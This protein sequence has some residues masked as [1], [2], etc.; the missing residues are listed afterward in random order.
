MQSKAFAIIGLFACVTLLSADGDAFYW[1]NEPA[2]ASS[3]SDVLVPTTGTFKAIVFVVEFP[4]FDSNYVED[5]TIYPTFYDSLIAPNVDV[6]LT[7]SN[8]KWSITNFIYT[9]SWKQL[10]GSPLRTMI[11]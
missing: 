11:F 2:E 7:D 5:D 4:D 3:P 1:W 9:A 10:D 6:A 8:Y